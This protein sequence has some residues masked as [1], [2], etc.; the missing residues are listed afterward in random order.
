M[1][2]LLTIVKLSEAIDNLRQKRDKCN[3]ENKQCCEFHRVSPLKTQCPCSRCHTSVGSKHY[4]AMC[5]FCEKMNKLEKAIAIHNLRQKRDK[6][7]MQDKWC[8]EN[9]R[10]LPFKT[11]C[12][13]SRCHTSVGSRHYP[14]MC[15]FCKKM[16]KLEKEIS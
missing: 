10:I 15:C 16:T 7:N 3:M 8:C 4:P 9:H 14:A 11:M 5:C 12:P 1:L 2:A 13:C 6:C